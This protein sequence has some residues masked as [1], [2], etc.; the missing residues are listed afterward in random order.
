MGAATLILADTV[1]VGMI[2]IYIFIIYCLLASWIV[3]DRLVMGT[4][5]SSIELL[6]LVSCSVSRLRILLSIVLNILNSLLASTVVFTIS[7][8]DWFEFRLAL[9]IWLILILEGTF[10]HLLFCIILTHQILLK[11]ISIAWILR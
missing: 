11:N 10:T 8:T 4:G 1:I 6:L 7:R 5:T 2:D 9:Y 3:L